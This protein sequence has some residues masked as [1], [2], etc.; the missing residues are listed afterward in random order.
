MGAIL[1]ILCRLPG[2]IL[3]TFVFLSGH[4]PST[5]FMTPLSVVIITFNEERNIGRCL[6][7][8]GGVTDDIVVID[9]FSTDKT[10]EI[11][12]SHS[13]RYFP[14][15]WEGYSA[16]KNFGNTQA[17]HDWILSLDADEALSDNLRDSIHGWKMKPEPVPAKFSRL[18]NYC[19]KW[20]RHGGWYPDVKIRIFNRNITRWSGLIHE[21]LTGIDEKNAVFLPGD[22]YHFTYYSV[23]E[24][25]AKTEYF[26]GMAAD[27]LFKQG[28]M[29][30]TF[31]LYTS[32]AAK[33]LRDYFLRLGFLDGT[34][35]YNIARISAYAAWLKY[36]KLRQLQRRRI[37]EVKKT[38]NKE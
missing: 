8:V 14:H 17:K 18:A 12:G 35:G 33:F 38:G 10:K 3:L 30:G 11:C 19:G 32:P 4:Q 37:E 24:H 23:E 34:T 36:Y 25:L 31:S 7:S 1:T 22:C 6:D 27:D 28:K 2:T 9:S 5:I 29:A 15:Q 26:A 13:V 21:K 20:I 16:S